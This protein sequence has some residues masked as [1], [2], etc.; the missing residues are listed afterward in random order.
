MEDWMERQKYT[1]VSPAVSRA[2]HH[3]FGTGT[4]EEQSIFLTLLAPLSCISLLCCT[5]LL[6]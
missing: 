6:A 2:D 4:A 1:R 3:V 5:L